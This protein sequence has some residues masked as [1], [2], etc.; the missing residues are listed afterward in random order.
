MAPLYGN[1]AESVQALLLSRRQRGYRAGVDDDGAR[2]GLVVEGGAFRAVHSAGAVF[3]LHRLGF[4]QVFDGVYG[5]SSGA[6][7]A[8][9]FLAGQ[10]EWATLC[11]YR[12]LATRQLFNPLRW[13]DLGDIHWLFDLWIDGEN[14]LD[15]GAVM[16]SRSDFYISAT[17]IETAET[18][19]FSNRTDRPEVVVPALKASCSTPLFVSNQ[20]RIDGRLYNDGMVRASLP[21]AKAIDD[22]CTHLLA[23]LTRPW[24][25]R[26]RYSRS[27][28]LWIKLRLRS[29]PEAYRR[30]FLE[31]YRTYNAALE[32]VAD[33]GGRLVT[34]AIAP[35]PGELVVKNGEVDSQRLRRAA[36]EG[37]VRVARMFGGDPREVVLPDDE[38]PEDEMT[39]EGTPVDEPDRARSGI[40]ELS[41]S[42]SSKAEPSV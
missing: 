22:G 19:Y 15:V 26:D 5:T 24:G 4:Q 3:A 18:R 34:W 9:Y 21:V 17:D 7:N 16:R 11:Y 39:H 35:A 13:P 27:L 12:H 20:E 2:V 25:H 8:A 38:T 40:G 33:G 10:V 36:H 32:V 6:I 14:P 31:E 41:G 23:L 42:L 30:A 28:A 1:Q 37:A 29:Y